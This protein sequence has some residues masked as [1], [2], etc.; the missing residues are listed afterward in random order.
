[1]QHTKKRSLI[2]LAACVALPALLAA[3]ATPTP[4]NAGAVV[5]APQ[6]TLP[7]PPTL[8]QQT[9]PLP[10]GYFQRRL[11]DYFSSSPA[12][13]TTSTPPTPAAVQTRTP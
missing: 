11:A 7:P 1:M 2:Y 6:V 4:L 8:V 13:P 10:A 5:V 9:Q 12:K 3:C